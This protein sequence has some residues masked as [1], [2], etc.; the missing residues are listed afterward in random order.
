MFFA[1]ESYKLTEVLH[2]DFPNFVDRVK[3]HKFDVTTN[4]FEKLPEILCDDKPECESIQLIGRI[5]NE[6]VIKLVPKEI[7]QRTW[8]FG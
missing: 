1:P 7:H 3:G 8:E 5:N 2:S 6:R 4:I